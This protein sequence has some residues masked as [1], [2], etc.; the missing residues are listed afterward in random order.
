MGR[1]L[2]YGVLALTTIM[3][4]GALTSDPAEARRRK[5]HSAKAKISAKAA[6][7]YTP[8]YSSLVVDANTGAVLQNTNADALRHPASL[9]KIMTLYLL[10]ERLEAGK[11]SLA[12]ELRVSAHAAAQS[13]SKLNLSPG[14]TIDVESAIKAV[15]TK[16]ANDVAVVIA[17]NLGG[18]E[19]SFA[20][21]MTQKA[22]ALGMK[23]TTYH[24]ASGLPNEDQWTTARDQVTLGRAIQERFPRYYRYFS[25]RTFVYEG[26]ALRN[27]NKLLGRVEGVDGIKTGYVNASGF[28]LVTSVRRA[29][30]HVVAAIFGGRSGRARDA[31]MEGL[32]GKYT[33]LASTKQTAPAIA[34]NAGAAAPRLAAAESI[35]VPAARPEPEAKPEVMDEPKAP[36]PRLADNRPVQT[37]A[38][39]ALRATAYTPEVGSKEPIRPVAVK[40]LAVKGSTMQTASLAPVAPSNTRITTIKTASGTPDPR[41]E[42]PIDLKTNNQAVA[43]ASAEAKAEPAHT[44]TL[45]LS[46]PGAKPGV[47]GVLPVQVASA[48]P[49]AAVT[50][51]TAAHAKARNGWF[52]QVGA[53]E[54]EK[55]AKERLS[56]V[57][58]AVKVLLKNAEA[59][60]E[61]V[62]KGSRTFYRARFAGFDEAGAAKACREVK[63]SKF[64]CMPARN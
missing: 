63:A 59:Y 47:L 25:T 39:R 38:A 37:D 31:Q 23:N 57:R 52:I 41:F 7:A 44:D 32:I 20:R 53:L 60:T 15:V 27:H 28:N 3:V 18:D 48:D 13:P 51:S 58:S 43:M 26:T 40:T 22:R 6:R 17:E 29:G 5:H 45:P 12:S 14:D 61:T 4:A 36:A 1:G 2:R 42:K 34:E 62:K 64:V 33:M 46:P 49:A 11:I 10:F 50:A 24:N 35:P 54:S 9:T 56:E 55:E 16:S 21:L 8:P 19:P 30:R